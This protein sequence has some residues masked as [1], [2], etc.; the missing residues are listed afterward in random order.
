MTS[1][2]RCLHLLDPDAPARLDAAFAG[3]E[4]I[5]MPSTPQI[6]PPVG[7]SG[8]LMNFINSG[9]VM[10]RCQSVRRCVHDFAKVVRRMFRG[11]ADGDA[12]A[13]V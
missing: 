3:R 12:G 2:S 13:A 1:C 8:P 7:K 11:H 6:M 4:I 5:L 10:S 9:I